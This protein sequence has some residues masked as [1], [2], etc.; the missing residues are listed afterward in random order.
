MYEFL[1]NKMPTSRISS[2]LVVVLESAVS[3]ATWVAS[4]SLEL[5]ALNLFCGIHFVSVR[6][7]AA[8]RAVA[9]Y[10]FYVLF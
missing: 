2:L 1:M 9:H 8:C 7:A 3:G 4:F 10:F 6:F 5:G